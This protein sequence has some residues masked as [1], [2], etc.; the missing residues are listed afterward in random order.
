MNL[1]NK[2]N[3]F[4]NTIWSG[5]ERTSY[6]LIQFFTI[7]IVSH[8]LSPKDFGLISILTVF[9]VIGQT[10]VESGFGTAIIRETKIS[11]TDYSSLFYVNIIIGGVLYVILFFLSPYISAFYKEPDLYIISI[12]SFLVIPISATSIVQNAI[13]IKEMNFKKL[14]Y[15][16]LI[17]VMI[18]SIVC[19]TIACI[20]KNYWSL[21]ILNLLYCSIRSF[22]L[23]IVNSW[24]PSLIFSYHSIK[25][26]YKF[27]LSIMLSNCIGAVF[28]NIYS[29]II[30][31]FY[32][33]SI[34]GHYYQADRIKNMTSGNITD[35]IQRVVYPYM[36]NI[37]NNDPYL[38][39]ENYKKIIQITFMCVSIIMILIMGVS[40]ELVT[41]IF[42]TKWGLA[43]SFLFI[44]SING[45]L[46]PLHSINQN[47]LLVKGKSKSILELEIIRRC[48]MIII[49]FISVNLNIYYFIISLVVYSVAV[50]FINMYFCGKP[51]HYTIKC[52]FI[53]LFPFF[54]KSIIVLSIMLIFKT[55]FINL[56][57]VFRLFS[58]LMIG[59][60][61]FLCLYFNTYYF[62][63][64]IN[65]SI[66]LFKERIAKI[67]E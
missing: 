55:A 32:S 8:F 23:F 3:A 26:F 30:G 48:V 50:L 4:K 24:R 36:A 39:K 7:V 29:L 60:I 5:I 14:C 58:C 33:T 57:N 35:I 42:G 15:V 66:K 49:L 22:L 34:L 17:S 51:I 12:V 56:S 18:S 25:R 37:N 9:S 20:Y 41:F 16:S 1:I 52:Q 62:K 13:L 64:I 19:V 38:L 10:I 43:G 63:L 47:I 53:D 6:L 11:D 61:S 45:I 67:Y 2:D 44:L 54:M 28:N 27:S 46:Y 21:V 59:I 65:I 40:K 31:R